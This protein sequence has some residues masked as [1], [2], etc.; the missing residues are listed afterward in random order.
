MP[1][2]QSEHIL[3]GGSVAERV[4]RALKQSADR[5]GL[6]QTLKAEGLELY[7][8]G[9]TPGV[10][11]LESGKKHRLKTLGLELLNAFEA[12]PE[13]TLSQ[14]VEM[15]EFA[16]EN[17]KGAENEVV[18][19]AERHQAPEP[20]RTERQAIWEAELAELRAS[21]EQEKQSET[22]KSTALLRELK[23]LVRFAVNDTLRGIRSRALKMLERLNLKPK[24]YEHERLRRDPNH[25]RGR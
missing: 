22:R 7:V 9:K 5:S 2:Q 18:R 10:I 19:E 16:G 11:E 24:H 12:L 21:Q 4:S 15:P 1:D 13:E 20:E 3:A 17:E 6:R 14:T 8:R 23:S 25:Q